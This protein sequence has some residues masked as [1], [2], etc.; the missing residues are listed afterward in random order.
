MPV[1]VNGDIVDLADGA[2][3]ARAVGRGGSDDRARRAGAALARR[4]DR[5]GAGR[6]R[7]CAAAP[8]GDELAEI[9]VEHYEG[10]LTEYGIA[11]GVRAARK[12]LDWYLEAARHRRRPGDAAGTRRSP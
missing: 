5:G 10:V 8:T 9:V 12:H 1:V 7:R 4:A 3:G 11:V 2:R 6:A